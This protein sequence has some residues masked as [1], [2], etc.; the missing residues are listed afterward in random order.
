MVVG[1]FEIAKDSSTLSYGEKHISLH[2]RRRSTWSIER[3]HMVGNRE[4]GVFVAQCTREPWFDGSEVPKQFP[5]RSF[6]ELVV[7]DSGGR[8][9][10]V[11]QSVSHFWLFLLLLGSGK[12]KSK[13][14]VHTTN[15]ETTRD[16]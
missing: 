8:A 9:F 13:L 5:D 10:L 7:G 11:S 12:P 2:R 1:S 14:L 16:R 6:L 15:Q 3:G 4:S